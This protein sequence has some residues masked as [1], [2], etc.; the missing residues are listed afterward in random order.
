MTTM[1]TIKK[2]LLKLINF[3]ENLE[4]ALKDHKINFIEGATLSGS[5]GVAV[6]FIVQNFNE[7]FS[8]LREAIKNK[9]Q[10]QQWFCQELDLD[11]DKAEKLFE[12]TFSMLLSIIEYV[13]IFKKN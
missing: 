11:N 4:G 5:L 6:F 2:A 9:E 10:L 1:D 13:E 7:I 12:K 3:G 8:E